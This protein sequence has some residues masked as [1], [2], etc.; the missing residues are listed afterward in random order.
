VTALEGSGIPAG[1]TLSLFLASR[2]DSNS[3]AIRNMFVLTG[4]ILEISQTKL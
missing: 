4:K 2:N 1:R 3:G